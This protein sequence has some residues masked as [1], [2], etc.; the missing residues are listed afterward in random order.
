MTI[1]P[2]AQAR[3][4]MPQS[5]LDPILSKITAACL[6]AARQ[7]KNRAQFWDNGDHG[8]KDIG[9][10]A[11]TGDLTTVAQAVSSGLRRLGYTVM[12]ERGSYIDPRE[13]CPASMIVTW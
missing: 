7:G 4:A 13:P 11:E 8:I 1:Y 12:F 2:A 10:M 6:A 9:R 3:A 5:N